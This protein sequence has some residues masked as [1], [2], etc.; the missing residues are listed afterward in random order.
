MEETHTR[1]RI[2]IRA[3]VGGIIRVIRIIITMDG[4]VIRIT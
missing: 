1:I 3:K 2:I 4:G